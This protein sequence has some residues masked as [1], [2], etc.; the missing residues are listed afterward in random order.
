M[1]PGQP[2]DPAPPRPS[3][4]RRDIGRHRCAAL[5]L[6]GRGPLLPD[7]PGARCPLSR[8]SGRVPHRGLPALQGHRDVDGGPDA[9]P[10]GRGGVR[11]GSRR[12]R[13]RPLRVGEAGGGALSVARHPAAHLHLPTVRS[14]GGRAGRPGTGVGE[15]G[16]AGARR[17]RP[18]CGHLRQALARVARSGAAADAPRARRLRLRRL[19]G[20]RVRRMDRRRRG[21]RHP[22]GDHLPGGLGLGAGIQRGRRRV[23]DHRTPSVRA[24]REPD[25]LRARVGAGAHGR[26][27]GG[28][29]RRGVAAGTSPR[30]RRLRHAGA[31]GARRP[32][33][34]VPRALTAVRGM[35]PSVG[36]RGVHGE[37]PVVLAHADPGGDHGRAGDDVVRGPQHG[38]GPGTSSS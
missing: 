20:P 19:L 31:G 36:R 13:C 25:R 12:L 14:G 34:P 30:G 18:R 15:A 11:R 3:R 6:G 7:R 10:A 37:P 22:T 28:N 26:P 2:R 35:A 38:S 9:G 8:L 5:P 24:G 29:L 16:P 32:P 1:V 21:G 23:G 4:G 27:A 17:S 33:V